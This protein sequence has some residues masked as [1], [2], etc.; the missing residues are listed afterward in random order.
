LFSQGA[1]LFRGCEVWCDSKSR[2]D[3]TLKPQTGCEC[4]DKKMMLMNFFLLLMILENDAD[5]IFF[6]AY[7]F[8][9]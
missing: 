7:D 2:S 3:Y 1:T 4:K 6:V 5:E 9:K 8:G